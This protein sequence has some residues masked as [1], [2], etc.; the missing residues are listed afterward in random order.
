MRKLAPCQHPQKPLSGFLRGTFEHILSKRREGGATSD[1]PLWR[2]V[3]LWQL[4]A[5]KNPHTI[6][7]DKY[8]PVAEEAIDGI[9][10]HE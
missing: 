4:Q 7:R 6:A 9:K 3:T 1:A 10:A 5:K 2:G 8:G